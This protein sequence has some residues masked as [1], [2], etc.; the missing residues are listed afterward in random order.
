MRTGQALVIA[1]GVLGLAVPAVEARRLPT[2]AERAAIMRHVDRQ[3]YYK[4]YGREC[5]AFALRVSTVD[6]HW[7]AVTVR[8][9]KRTCDVQGDVQ[10]FHRG[11]SGWRSHQL[12]N[13]GGCNM[14]AAVR[15]D[16][17]LACY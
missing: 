14:P 5:V 3:A 10:S 4:T 17:R 11:R 15:D 9:A 13:G 6:S 16:L 1:I 8:R 7:A 12:G 2:R